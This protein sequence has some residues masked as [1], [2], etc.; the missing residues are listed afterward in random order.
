MNGFGT[1]ADFERAD[2]KRIAAGA[3]L[4]FGEDIFLFQIG[5]AGI[6]NDISGEIKNAFES[7]W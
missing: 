3:E 5:V 4:P 1:D 2:A 7:A 6:E